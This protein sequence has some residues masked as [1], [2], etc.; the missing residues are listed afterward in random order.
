MQGASCRYTYVTNVESE[1]IPLRLVKFGHDEVVAAG[2]KQP[3]G[4]DSVH[5]GLEEE[6][7]SEDN[8]DRSQGT[9]AG[10]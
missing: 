9:G 6:G 2:E 4:D 1:R 7:D 5:F 8:C 10:V 3:G